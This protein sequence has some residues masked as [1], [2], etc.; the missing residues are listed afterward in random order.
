MAWEREMGMRVGARWAPAVTHPR[1]GDRA[2]GFSA[3]GTGLACHTLPMPPGHGNSPAVG[4]RWEEMPTKMPLQWPHESPARGLGSGQGSCGS[5][6][7]PA[8]YPGVLGCVHPV[9]PRS[10]VSGASGKSPGTG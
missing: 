8:L 4:G 6:D 2:Q 1:Q 5:G 9:H 10:T 7:N 3:L